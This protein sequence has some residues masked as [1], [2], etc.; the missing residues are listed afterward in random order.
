M[1]ISEAAASGGEEGEEEEEVDTQGAA[2][3]SAPL[4]APN[5]AQ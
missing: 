5:C 4:S 1:M 3:Q 2:L